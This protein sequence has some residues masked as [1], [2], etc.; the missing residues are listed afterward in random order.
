MPESKFTTNGPIVTFVNGIGYLHSVSLDDILG[1]KPGT[2]RREVDVV[3]PHSDPLR[4]CCIDVDEADAFHS[5]LALA[6]ASWI[7]DGGR[8]DKVIAWS[9]HARLASSIKAM[10]TPKAGDPIIETVDGMVHE[11]TDPTEQARVLDEWMAWVE[12]R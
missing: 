3:L 4:V 6:W 5:D 11:V 12:S 2:C 9:D 8:R 1:I 7:Q 10:R